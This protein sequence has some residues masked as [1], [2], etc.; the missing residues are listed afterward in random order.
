MDA[1]GAIRTTPMVAAIPHLYISISFE[2]TTKN[3]GHD[4]ARG[5]QNG[6]SRKL[7]RSA[8]IEGSNRM[9]PERK[10]GSRRLHKTHIKRNEDRDARRD[11]TRNLFKAD[12]LVAQLAVSKLLFG[13][14]FLAQ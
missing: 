6:R 10:T 13:R 4:L 2:R 9:G 7:G 3:D 1:T 12:T 11:D 14:R 5:R 8:A